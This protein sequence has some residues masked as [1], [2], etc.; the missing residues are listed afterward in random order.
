MFFMVNFTINDR[1]LK[2]AEG[3]TVL[4]VALEQGI[5]IP[6]LCY[7]KELTPYGAC[8]LCLVEI[9]G[10]GRLGLEASCVYK[11]TDGLEVKT[12]TEKVKRAR[13]IVFE[14]LLARCPDAEKIRK[15]ARDYGVT[16]TRITLKKRDNCIL[17]G[18]CVRVCAEISQRHA[19][20]FSGRGTRRKIQTP[21]DKVSERCIGCGACAYLCPVEALKIEEAD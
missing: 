10:G 2:V 7:H 4:E 1:Q 5:E 16:G 11:I 15:L 6:T 19:Q 17:C 14:L 13:K 8:R 18:L 12:D 3:R 9:V 20:S 21:F